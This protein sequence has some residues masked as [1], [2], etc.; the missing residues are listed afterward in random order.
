MVRILVASRRP[1]AADAFATSSYG[2]YL[3]PHPLSAEIFVSAAVR[4]VFPWSTCPIVPTFTWGLLRSNF[5]FAICSFSP[6]AGAGCVTD[7]RRGTQD[8]VDRVARLA[9][10]VY[11]VA[12]ATICS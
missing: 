8:A 9:P 10:C 5:A 3:V 4:V 7:A 2:T 11:L 12:L 1:C 6:T